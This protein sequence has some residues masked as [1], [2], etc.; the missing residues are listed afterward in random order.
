MNIVTH[1]W[2]VVLEKVITF[3]NIKIII[4]TFKMFASFKTI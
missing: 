3:H 2:N 4:V 1:L